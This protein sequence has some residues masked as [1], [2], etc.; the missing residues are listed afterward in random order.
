MELI[1]FIGLQGAGKSTFYRRNFA[2]THVLISKDLM[3]NNKKPARRQ[4]QLIKEN[5]TS[6]NSVVVDNTNPTREDR[7]AIIDIA[8]NYPA[9]VIG[10]YFQSKVRDCLQRNQQR[11]GKAKV[12]D[13]A[14]YI[15]QKKL[16]LP[17]Y[18]E[19]FDKLFYVKIAP[20]GEFAIA[21]WK[22]PEN[23]V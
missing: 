17:D 1:I 13:K 23:R 10:Y 18:R 20:S 16:V 8:K 21:P 14:I 6:G 22:L 5:L 12:P 9:M 4:A 7:A 11:T 3:R 19:G 15:T 2:Q